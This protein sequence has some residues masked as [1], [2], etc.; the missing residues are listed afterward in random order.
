[1]REVLPRDLFLTVSDQLFAIYDGN[2]TSFW[3]D[4]FT[5]KLWRDYEKGAIDVDLGNDVEY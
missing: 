1:M 3:P 5:F 4:R 2:S